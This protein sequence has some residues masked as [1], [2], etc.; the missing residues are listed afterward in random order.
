VTDSRR[1]RRQKKRKKKERERSEKYKERERKSEKGVGGVCV[2]Q[3]RIKGLL[4]CQE[5]WSAKW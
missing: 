4:N 2:Q 5:D 3:P 1:K